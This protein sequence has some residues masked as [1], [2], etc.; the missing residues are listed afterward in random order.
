MKTKIQTSLS[1]L[2]LLFAYSNSL[3]SQTSVFMCPQTGVYGFC[4]GRNNTD[5]CA[6]SRT[7]RHGGQ[8]PVSI[9]YT[10]RRGFGAVAVGR[11]RMGFR[12]TGA[13]GGYQTPHQARRRALRECRSVGGRLCRIDAVWFDR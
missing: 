3:H 12:V 5:E 10:Q 4:F 6:I 2:F 9:F 8:R 13:S 1:I 7:I 11:D